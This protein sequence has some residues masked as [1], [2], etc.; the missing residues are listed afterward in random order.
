MIDFLWQFADYP[1][2]ERLFEWRNAGYPI[3]PS[4]GPRLTIWTFR[5]EQPLSSGLTAVLAEALHWLGPARTLLVTRLEYDRNA[6]SA[7]TPEQLQMEPSTYAPSFTERTAK[8]W[9]ELNNDQLNVYFAAVNGETAEWLLTGDAVQLTAQLLDLSVELQTRLGIV[10]PRKPDEILDLT[11]ATAVESLLRA[12]GELNIRSALINAG[13]EEYHDA[14]LGA[15]RRMIESAL[16]GSRFACWAACHGLWSIAADPTP[17]YRVEIERALGSLGT[18][19]PHV[20]WPFLALGILTWATDSAA[21]AIELFESAVEADPT[22]AVGWRLLAYIYA[23]TDGYGAA[24]DACNEAIGA[25]VADGAL[26]YA[27]GSIL[28]ERPSEDEAEVE[29][30]MQRARDSFREAEQRGI[31]TPDLYLNLMDTCDLLDDESGLWAAFDSLLKADVDG[32]AL[33]MAIEDADTYDDFEPGLTALHQ[34]IEQTPDSY[35]LRAAYVRALIVLDRREEAQAELPHLREIAN[36]DYARSEAAQLAL[37]AAAP[38]FETA[39]GELVDELESGVIADETMIG[40]LKDA[41]A[42]E[43]LFADSASYLALAYESRDEFDLALETLRQARERLPDHLELTLSLAELLWEQD[44]DEEAVRILQNALERQPDDVALLARLGEYF[45]QSNEDDLA[46]EYLER[47]EAIDPRNPEMMR[48]RQTIGEWIGTDDDN[49][50]EDDLDED[51][52]S[53]EDSYENG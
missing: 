37:E 43:P 13:Y 34:G 36:D 41:L 16:S 14:L 53:A 38:D 3:D 20:A 11:D 28:L 22:L 32:E 21:S 25:R 52:D 40:L 31:R 15:I 30:D 5:G 45:F 9:G 23:E 17:D 2:P 4:R 49:L 19:F 35:L 27:L 33:W 24:I 51:A 12:W 1:L 8:V 50:D 6:P 26:Y 46:R 10:E 48:V 44:S 47:A 42:R 39:Y 29:A 18:A 7:W